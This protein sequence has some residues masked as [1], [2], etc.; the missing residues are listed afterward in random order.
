MITPDHT[1]PQGLSTIRAYDATRRFVSEGEERQDRNLR[2]SLLSA[3]A[4]CWLGL[5]LE[6]IGAT[7]ATLV[8]LLAFRG[9]GMGAG[10]G[11]GR[12]ALSV[13]L[14]MQVPRRRVAHYLPCCCFL[15]LA[16][17]HERSRR[18]MRDPA[19][20]PRHPAP[21]RAR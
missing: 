3:L 1:L 17:R 12:A 11:V 7:I 8:T 21:H 9:V 6:L 19:L 5:R 20:M 14:A 18:S 2:A 13:T 4:N 16:H 15:L 10:K